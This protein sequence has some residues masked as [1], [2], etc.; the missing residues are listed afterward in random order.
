MKKVIHNPT[1]TDIILVS[2]TTPDKFYLVVKYNPAFFNDISF[3]R[4]E[5]QKGWIFRNCEHMS[6]GYS[7]LF[8]SYTDALSEII[9]GWTVYQF[10]SFMEAI[11]YINSLNL[12]RS[13]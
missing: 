13:S 1:N 7:G 3:L 4:Y 2:Q 8:S 6:Y 11:Q 9:E 12:V 5:Q 10:D